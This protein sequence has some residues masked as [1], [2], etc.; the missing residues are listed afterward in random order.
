MERFAP[1]CPDFVV[2]IRSNPEELN[3]LKAKM[4]EYLQNGALLGWL[5]DRLENKVY[6]YSQNKE[7]IIHHSLDVKLSGGA[8]LPGFV[9]DL[10]A[11]IK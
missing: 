5:I 3:Y 10:G 1:I 4:E 9:L 6:V 7:M 8:T 11:I 2:E